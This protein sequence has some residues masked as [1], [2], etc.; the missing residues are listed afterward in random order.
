MMAR[1]FIFLLLLLQLAACAQERVKE[2]SVNPMALYGL[3]STTA[4]LLKKD[5]ETF[6]DDVKNNPFQST[7]IDK[8]YITQDPDAFVFFNTVDAGGIYQPL[9]MQVTRLSTGSFLIKLAHTKTTET[10]TIIHSIYN[11]LAEQQAKGFIF[12]SPSAYYTAAMQAYTTGS[13]SYRYTGEIDKTACRKMDAINQGM[14]AIFQ[15]PVK[16]VTYYKFKNAVALFNHLGF[17]YLPNM[18]FDTTGGIIK[19]EAGQVLAANNSEIYEHEFVHLYTRS[20]ND[21]PINHYADEGVATLIGGSGGIAYEA[22]IK[23]V[24]D[25]IR[26][27]NIT[28]IYEG[29]VGDF[30]ID[31]KVSVKYFL[32]ALICKLIKDRKGMAGLTDV[33]KVNNTLAAFLGKTD[34]ILQ[35]NEHNFNM[36]MMELLEQEMQ[37]ASA[38]LL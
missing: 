14:A 17:D 3:D 35:L 5:L 21:G 10:G 6:L 26:E 25:R 11:L 30:Q 31:K 33:L 9:L 7:V 34:E 8:N 19:Y 4:R 22:G 2:M 1:L 28:N 29:F 23:R 18:Y 24:Y 36:R 20:V 16:Q 38:K 32:S 27:K 12:F 37:K 15:Q 13:V